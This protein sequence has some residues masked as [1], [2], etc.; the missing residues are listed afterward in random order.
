MV[1]RRGGRA[2]DTGAST[3]PA[4]V[5]GLNDRDSITNMP[6]S[7]AVILENWWPQPS[8]VS[9][10]NGYYEHA[11]GLPGPVETLVEYAP[12]DGSIQ[13]LAACDGGIYDVTIQGPVGAPEVAGQSSDRWQPVAATT[14]GGSYLY[15]FNG[16]D[17]PLLYDGSTW[18][19]VDGS[20]VP[21][22]TGI[23]DTTRIIDGCVFKNRGYLVERNSMNLW[24]LP[25]SAIGGEAKSI[26]MGQIFRRGGW[27]A[28]V[29]TWTI[30]AGEG[31]DDH[32]VVISSNGEVAVF[33]GHDP[34]SITGW[35]LVGVFWLGRPVG[36]RPCIKFGGDLLVIAE[37]GVFPLGKGL[38]SSSIDRRVAL[39]DKIQNV[40]KREASLL[41]GEFG[42]QL[43]V[44]P[45]NAALILNVPAGAG[46]NYQFVQNTITGAWAK[47]TGWDARS[48]LDSPM[49][50][51]FGGNG[52]VCRAWQGMTDGTNQ[53]VADALQAFGYF[54]SKSQEK[55]FT[56]IRPYLMTT[57]RPSVMYGMNGDFTPDEPGGELQYYPPP[58]MIWGSMIW[59]SMIWGGSMQQLFEWL[60]VGRVAKS[61][62]P[63]LRVQANG[64]ELEWSATDVLFTKGWWL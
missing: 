64:A 2:P 41:K 39:T 33:A 4:P 53:I 23:T 47:F 36:Q 45:D 12:P 60:T 52:V 44:S 43:C 40:I 14:A 62:A 32:L 49:G 56:M 5:G 27:I 58:G 30:D 15:L 50:L 54:G 46:K 24:Y 18:V 13:L 51:F 34:E 61:G 37:D 63:R 8:R 3:I 48:W 10:R 55:Y 26:A 6:Q 31:S 35:R 25:L 17:K 7:D 9:V 38:L 59:G 57:G 20:S 16:V 29:Q 42:W 28:T 11:T 19:S 1:R 22:I 21:A